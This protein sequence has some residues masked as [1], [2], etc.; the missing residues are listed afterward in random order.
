M[1]GKNVC[2]LDLK[3]LSFSL[4]DDPVMGILGMDCLRHYCIQFDFEA[5]TMPLPGP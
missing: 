3:S 5:G 1:T 4:P 2:T